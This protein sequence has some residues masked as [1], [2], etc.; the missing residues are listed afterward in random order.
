MKINF[1]QVPAHDVDAFGDDNLFGPDESGNF[2]YNFVEFGT[3]PGGTEEVAIVDG[4]DRFMPIAVDSIPELIAALGECYKIAKAL[5]ASQRIQDY[6][7][8]D[9]QAYVTED[10]IDYEPIQNSASWP[11]QY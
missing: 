3:N 2:Y 1:A 11:F 9:N 4:C 6:V 5:E 7:T 8:Q 10:S